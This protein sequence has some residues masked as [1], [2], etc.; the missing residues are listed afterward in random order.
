MQ[1]RFD[2]EAYVTWLGKEGDLLARKI[3]INSSNELDATAQTLIVHDKSGATG[4]EPRTYN[5][6]HDQLG[7]LVV[8]WQ[9]D[10]GNN[11]S[12]DIFAP[13]IRQHGD[14]RC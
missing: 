5:A 8:V 9:Q 6:D 11:L 7:G 3:F 12:S 4:E 2:N 14:F 13:K 1:K 10:R